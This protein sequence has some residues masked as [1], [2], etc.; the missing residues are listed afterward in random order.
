MYARFYID[1]T[2]PCHLPLNNKIYMTRRS[3]TFESEHTHWSTQ[4]FSARYQI[5][6]DFEF[7][8]GYRCLSAAISNQT[9]SESW[10]GRTHM[11]P[12]RFS[13]VSEA[14]SLA[15]RSSF[16]CIVLCEDG[17]EWSGSSG[18]TFTLKLGWS[19]SF[20]LH[21]GKSAHIY[22][23]SIKVDATK[24]HIRRGQSAGNTY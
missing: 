15:S 13:P 17:F 11:D 6:H 23:S 3:I 7:C 22:S 24:M 8:R 9:L 12:L 10:S 14:P 21:T 2:H 16:A 20:I 19:S 4:K 5:I 1:S 18:C